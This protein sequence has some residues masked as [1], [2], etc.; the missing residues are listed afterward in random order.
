[1]KTLLKQKKRKNDGKQSLERTEMIALPTINSE[2]RNSY[3]MRIREQSRIPT[4]IETSMKTLAV[5]IRIAR[6]IYPRRKSIR[7]IG[8]KNLVKTPDVM[9]PI[10]KIPKREIPLKMLDMTKSM[11][12]PETTC[13]MPTAKQSMQTC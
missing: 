7:S 10:E 2:I 11:P 6:I 8:K 4:R 1:K 13:N 3:P 12:I 9:T 5:M